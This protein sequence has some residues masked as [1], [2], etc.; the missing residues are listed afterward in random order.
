MTANWSPPNWLWGYFVPV[1]LLLLIWGGLNQRKAR[2]I[3]SL[4]GFSI[5]L[6]ALC[7]WAVGFAFHMGGAQAVHPDDPALKGLGV[8]FTLIPENPGWGLIGLDAFFLS[9]EALGSRIYGYFLSYLPLVATSV[10]LVSLALVGIRRWMILTT[11]VLTASVVIPVA[12]CWVWGSGWLAHLGETMGFGFGYVDFGGSSLILWIPSMMLLGFLFVQKPLENTKLS[13]DISPPTNASLMSNF[14]VLL[15]GLGWMGWT[16]SNPFHIADANLHWERTALSLLLGMAGATLMSQLYAW[17]TTGT[18]EV[19]LA[20]RGLAAGWAVVLVGAPFLSP[21]L[22]LVLGLLTGLVFPFIHYAV[23]SR[24]NLRSAAAS[25]TIGLTA[26]PIGV[27]GVALFADGRWGQGWN[28]IAGIG[29]KGL[30]NADQNLL[31]VSGFFITKDIAQLKAQVIGLAALGLWGLIWG[32]AS[33]VFARVFATHPPQ[34]QVDTA[35]DIVSDTESMLAEIVPDMNQ[36]MTSDVLEK[37]LV[38][39]PSKDDLPLTETNSVDVVPDED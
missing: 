39:A 25:L 32:I 2:Q 18:P 21:W 4:V 6:T 9:G 27:F 11:C 38:D 12:L 14:G 19:L 36:E 7:Y 26:G 8:L 23:E 33:G 30:V 16:L 3:T 10:L 28:S 5:A 20:A 31:G 37:V 17:L 13:P 15:M 34:E 22:A 35:I 24:V 1:G 29:E